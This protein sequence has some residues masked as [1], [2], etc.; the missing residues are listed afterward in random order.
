MNTQY[1]LIWSGKQGCRYAGSK[2]DV[3]SLDRYYKKLF[4]I[5]RSQLNHECLA[6]VP[7]D[8]Q[9][10][11]VGCNNGV[12]LQCLKEMGFMDVMGVE[13]NPLA[14]KK[15][16]D[17]GVCIEQGYGQSLDFP[18]QT[19]D[20]VFTSGVLIHIPP[21]E[22]S[23]V[24]G[25]MYRVTKNGGWLWGFEYFHPSC[26]ERVYDG[27]RGL[28]WANNFPLLFQ[29]LFSDLEPAYS[30]FFRYDQRNVGIMYLLKKMGGV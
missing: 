12:Q 3:K 10:L 23:L 18:D 26:I 27:K 17:N 22:L 20:L 1:K 30:R 8:S 6:G 13:P 4:G 14:V 2:N 28:C 19:F 11:E 25:E 29:T 15:Y 16:G 24:L 5:T 9:V 7:L 21:D